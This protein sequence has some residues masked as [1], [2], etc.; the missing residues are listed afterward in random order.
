MT[1]R[2]IVRPLDETPTDGGAF[3]TAPSPTPIGGLQPT[4][5]SR[6]GAIPDPDRRGSSRQP[7]CWAI[8]T[9][10]LHFGQIG[11]REGSRTG[12]NL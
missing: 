3:M 12:S 1:P 6:A 7:N 2:V 4:R 5:R 9:S 8:S 10:S 11:K